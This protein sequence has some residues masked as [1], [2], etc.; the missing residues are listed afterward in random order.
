MLSEFFK[1]G[2]VAVHAVGPSCRAGLLA[3]AAV[4]IPLCSPAP[5]QAWVR[6]LP[7]VEDSTMAKGDEMPFHGAGNLPFRGGT[8]TIH[9]GAK[10]PEDCARIGVERAEAAFA[11]RVYGG[12]LSCLDSS[13]KTLGRIEF[14]HFGIP[15]AADGVFAAAAGNHLG[16]YA[17]RSEAKI[18]NLADKFLVGA[19]LSAMAGAAVIVGAVASAPRKQSGEER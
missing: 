17:E 5:A 7:A 2:H 18:G 11:E 8:T 16:A 13:G 6:P 12:S 19:I 10:T 9:Y 3:A 14:D 1:K 15:K 4:L